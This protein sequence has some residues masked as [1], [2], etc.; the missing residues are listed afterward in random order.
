MGTLYEAESRYTDAVDA[1]RQALELD[2]NDVVALNNIALL[3]SH[4]G[5]PQQAITYLKQA[6]SVAG[7]RSDLLDSR[8]SVRLAMGD[9]DGAIADFTSAIADKPSASRWLHLA[10]A[11]F[12]AHHTEEA[13]KAF[14]RALAMGLTPKQ[15]HPFDQS[16][17]ATLNNQFTH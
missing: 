11:Q 12:R 3:L 7:P 14:D 6:L 8:G 13:Q 4:Q 1:Y 10:I 15:V 5:N 2:P 17:Y 16:D 9:N